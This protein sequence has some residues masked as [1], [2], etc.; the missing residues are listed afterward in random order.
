MGVAFLLVLWIGGMRLAAHKISLGSFVMFNTYMGMLVWPMIAMGWVANL[1]ERGQAS[2]GRVRA[3]L[4]ERPR[5]AAPASSARVA[6][7]AA[8]RDR[9]S[10]TSAVRYGERAALE[11]RESAYSGGRDRGDRRTHRQR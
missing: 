6:G 4:E 1:V 5:I 2:L 7:T 9:V 11:R 3:L 8:R 10:R